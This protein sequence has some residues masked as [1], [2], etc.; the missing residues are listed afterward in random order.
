MDNVLD[1]VHHQM[2]GQGCDDLSRCR[3]RE[4]NSFVLVIHV[5]IIHLT[6]QVIFFMLSFV[7]VMGAQHTSKGWRKEGFE[8][9]SCDFLLMVYSVSMGDTTPNSKPPNYI[10]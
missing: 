4:H 8:D 7:Y 5:A 9:R 3:C 2:S 6:V 1:S 10:R